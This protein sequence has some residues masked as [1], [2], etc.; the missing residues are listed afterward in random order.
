VSNAGESTPEIDALIAAGKHAD[1]ARAAAAAGLHARAAD[2]YEKIWDFAAAARAARSSGD[3]GRA[4][5]LALEARDQPLVAELHAELV[6]TED[7]ARTAV[8]L[9]ARARRHGDAAVLAEQIGDLDVAIDYYQRGHRDLDAARLLEGRGRDREAGRLLE[10][11]VELTSGDDRLEARLRLG[12]ILARR[13][14]YA[15]A[16]RHLQEV[17]N[18]G[19]P[20]ARVEALR[21]LVAVLAAMGLRDGAR[22]V[23]LELR[24]LD[25]GIAVDLDVYLR[26]WRDAAPVTDRSRDLLAGRYRLEQLLGSGGAGRV[27]LAK[28]EVSGRT[29]AVKVMHA[30]DARGSAAYERFLR[31][32]RVALALRHPSLVEVYEVSVEHGLLVMEYMPGGSLAQRLA[33]GAMPGALVKRMALELVA[34]LEMAHHRGV[35]HRDIKPA[36]VFFDARGTAKLGDFGVAHLLDLGQTQTGGLIGTLAYMSPEQITGAPLTI[37]ADLYA[38]G[39]TLF[40]ALTGRLPFLGP[41]FVAQH[42]GEEPPSP[43]SA[44]DDVA[45]GWDPILLGLLAKSPDDRT[46]SITAL[47]TQ[48]DALDLGGRPLVL[49]IRDRRDSKTHAITELAADEPS[50]PAAVKVRYQ[51]ETPLGT[52]ALSRLYRAVDTNLDRSVVIERFE[53]G[54]LADAALARVKQLGGASSPFVQRAL[55]LDRAARTAVFEAPAGAPFGEL[56]VEALAP[57]QILRMVKRLA[58]AIASLH[59]RGVTH[60][61]IAATTVVV[62]DAAVPTVMAAGLGAPP[63][64]ATPADDVVAVLGLAAQLVRCEATLPALAAT[65]VPSAPP[66]LEMPADGE[67][68]YGVIDALEVALVRARPA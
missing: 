24:R 40:E 3:E 30:A 61:G 43:T 66:R 11:L 18:S 20:A 37:T 9:Y 63:A 8:E 50:G 57:T 4:M 29:V 28:D 46:P 25:A 44:K 58:R 2:L 19:P 39:V 17:R 53:E 38:L 59:E 34:G 54:E 21:H 52:T 35:V 31:E 5:R 33:S 16:A 45:L 55:S 23:L 65:L 56:P 32:A 62:D 15:D 13:A 22:D 47:R 42:L 12:R 68:L 10:K 49:P 1:A 60:G 26:S 67:G 7:G 64:S 27:F 36:N 41:D 6:A 51:F 14:A 48:L